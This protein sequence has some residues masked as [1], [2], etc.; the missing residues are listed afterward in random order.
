[1]ILLEKYVKENRCIQ[2]REVEGNL[3]KLMKST[4]KAQVRKRVIKKTVSKI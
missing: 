2:C 4:K 3:E 1:M